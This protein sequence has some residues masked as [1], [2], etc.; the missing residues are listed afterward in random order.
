M[1]KGMM[2]SRVRRK[3][4]RSEKKAKGKRTM[5]TWVGELGTVGK[6]VLE[7]LWVCLSFPYTAAMCK[8]LG[9]ERA[10]DRGKVL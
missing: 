2:A 1:G 8:G 6:L 4:P 3:K 7:M 9:A 10:K 5:E